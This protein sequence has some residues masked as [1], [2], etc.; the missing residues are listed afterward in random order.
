MISIFKADDGLRRMILISSNSF[1]D[2]D[3]EIVKEA[4]L[5]EYVE[6]FMET[7]LLF[8]HGGAPIGTIVQAQ[9]QGPFMLELAKELPNKTID[10]SKAGEASFLIERAQV[11]DAIEAAKG[12]WGVSIGFQAQKKDG[13]NGLFAHILKFESSIIP[14]VNAANSFTYAAI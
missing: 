8:W 12:T 13:D 4:A 5:V 1:E 2:R 11:W 10:L 9:M 14:R 7:P 6:H 3:E